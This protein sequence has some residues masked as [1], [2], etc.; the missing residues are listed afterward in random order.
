[1]MEEQT[2]DLADYIAAFKRRRST[3]MLISVTIFVLGV[4][5][6]LVW[7]PT[8]RSSATILIEE[9][10]V[11]RELVQSTITTYAVQRIE[12]IR[13]RVMTRDKLMA[14][15]DKYNLY[16]DERRRETTEEI[17]TR[18]RDDIKLELKNADVID[19][20][21]GRPTPATIAFT[22]A[23]DGQGPVNTQKV[24]NE[25]TNL[26]LQENLKERSTKAQE[27]FSFLSDEANRLNREI[28]RLESDLA[29]FKE[30]NVNSLPELSQ[31]NTQLMERTDR[32]ISDTQN[33]IRSLEDRRF[34]LQGQLE[35]LDPHGID[36][37]LSPEARLKALRTEYLSMQGRYSPDHPDL[38]R[39]KREIESLERE[40]GLGPDRESLQKELDAKRTELASMK[41]KYSAQHPDV[42]NLKK[43]IAALEEQLTKIPEQPAAQRAPDNPAYV[44]LAAQLESTNNEIASL[45][46][47]IKELEAKRSDYEKRLAETPQVE[48][49]YS[50]LKRELDTDIAKYQE[51]KAK[52]MQAK[53]AKQLE[54]ESKGE[55]FTLI[56]PAALP[57]EPIKPNRPAIV[58]LSLVLA[59]GGGLGFAAVSESL[60]SSIRGMKGVA[61]TLHAVPLAAI[62]Y[63]QL[64]TEQKKK[65]TRKRWILLGIVAAVAIM[66]LVIHLFITPLDVLW[67]RILRKFSKE[68]GIDIIE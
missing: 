7:P 55:R 11:P 34:Y 22:L 33:Q 47:K 49:E 26:F 4:L 17:L 24:A 23:Y 54:S 63:L 42:V 25:L 53:V 43:E 60:D 36:V 8:Y 35:Q 64:D 61:Q 12:T 59:L 67:F 46:N 15:V 37:N 51:I 58:F 52:E 38:L 41:D 13:A 44:S 2:K 29:T 30:Q 62:P 18:M 40:T 57:E 10:E 32:D 20:R 3:I 27:T 5:I 66:L 21:T 50:S 68:T 1:M 65:R 14:I 19:P 6:A 45:K 28:N 56:E 31:L 16:P 39:T 48:R 9:Q